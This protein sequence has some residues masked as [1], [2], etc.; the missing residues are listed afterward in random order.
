MPSQFDE[1]K[2][3]KNLN[4]VMN[5]VRTEADA[6]FLAKYRSL[7]KKEVSF[8]SRSWA[9]AYLLMRY[10]QSGSGRYDKSRYAG[11]R[12]YGGKPQ[13][14]QSQEFKNDQN[15]N[16]LAEEDSKYLFI[17]IGRNRRVFSREILALISTHAQIQREDI[18][19]IRILD[20]YSFVQIRTPA[21]DAVIDALNGKSFR[22]RTLAVNYARSR[23]DNAG[24]NEIDSQASLETAEEN[25]REQN[26][27]EN[28]PE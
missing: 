27:E 11:D 18:G 9:A 1:E 26:P 28:S 7:F 17:S 12:K 3:R 4:A 10:D 21:A 6:E 14:R 19:A 25:Y 16:V 15:H 13:T 22:G 2:V 23:K 24:E 20:N 8:F 5:K